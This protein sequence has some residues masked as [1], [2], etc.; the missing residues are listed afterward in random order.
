MCSTALCL[1]GCYASHERVEPAAD[2][3]PSRFEGR[4]VVSHPFR[5]LYDE[6][7]YDLR[8]GGTLVEL[9]EYG[10]DP[11]GA[12][13]READGLR[14]DFTGPWDSRVDDELAILAYCE[15]S[16]ER[17]VV[18]RV[19]WS[20]PG[21]PSVSVDKVDGEEGWSHGS[22]EWVWEPCP[23]CDDVCDTI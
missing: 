5:A 3:G 6:V 22:F 15:D 16:V 23:A 2:A 4:W 9:C 7:R 12:V 21:A 18:L 1:A 11:P 20:A 13:R 14:C 10:T 17:M 19:D 8:A